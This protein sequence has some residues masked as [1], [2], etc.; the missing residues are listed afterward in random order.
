MHVP[1]QT[2]KDGLAIEID[3]LVTWENHLRALQKRRDELN[4]KKFKSPF[5]SGRRHRPHRQSTR[6]DTCRWCTAAQL[7]TKSGIPFVANLPTEEVF[8][9]PHKDSAEGVVRIVR[10]VTFGGAVIEGIEL[11]FQRRPRSSCACP[12][13]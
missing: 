11:E 3:A 7:R 8:T 4:G 2:P 5:L 10:P 12:N 13:R 9:L 1:A 6:W